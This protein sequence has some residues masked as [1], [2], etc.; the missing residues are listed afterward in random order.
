MMNNYRPIDGD[1]RHSSQMKTVQGPDGKQ[2]SRCLLRKPLSAKE[3]ELCVYL[4]SSLKIICCLWPTMMSLITDADHSTCAVAMA[5]AEPRAGLA[6]V[7]MVH[8][9]ALPLSGPLL[10]N[11]AELGSPGN[12][13]QLR[14]G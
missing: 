9:P 7:N 3:K 4:C 5:T 8:S 14:K 11:P 2:R 12:A 13:Q 10:L 6:D 1:G